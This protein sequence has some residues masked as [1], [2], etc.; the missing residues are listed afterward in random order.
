MK[1]T[2][3]IAGLIAC[4]GATNSYADIVI[5]QADDTPDM[6]VTIA[7]AAKDTQST[8]KRSVDKTSQTKR[9]DG[10]VVVINCPGHC[11]PD[12]WT[13]NNVLFCQCKTSDGQNCDVTEKDVIVGQSK[14]N[15]STS[16][17]K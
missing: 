16:V 1:K 3:L 10:G 5:S 13:L 11:T 4:I 8:K 17:T 15:T 7:R 2:F 12:C 6:V 14:P 9:A